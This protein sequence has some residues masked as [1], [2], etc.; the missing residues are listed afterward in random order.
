MTQT[1]GSSIDIQPAL[2]VAARPRTRLPVLT[3]HRFIALVATA[4]VA[5]LVV[6]PAWSA[7]VQSWLTA[8]VILTVVSTALE[9]VSVNLPFDGDLSVATIS[10]VATILLVP[11][12]FAALSVGLSILAEEVIRRRPVS[13]LVFNVSTY[14]VTVSAVSA[15]V[16]LIGAPPEAVAAHDNARV[17]AS[18]LLSALG[19]YAL[20]TA[21]VS[22][23]IALSSGRSVAF[24]LRA[25]TANTAIAET[26]AAMLGGLVALIWTIEPLWT[27]TLSLPAILVSRALHNIRR[28]ENETRDALRSMAQVIDHR[29]PTT[30]HHSERVAAYARALAEELELPDEEVEVIAQAA[31]V[32]D[33]GKIGIPDRILLKEGPLDESEKTVMWLHTEIGAAIVGQF[34]LFR[35]GVRIVLHHHERWDG[36]GYPNGLRGEEIPIGA[37]VVAVADAFDAMTEH[38]PYRA[39]LPVAEALARLQEGAG[40]QWDPAIVPAF[41]RLVRDGRLPQGHDTHAA[42]RGHAASHAADRP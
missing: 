14:I 9:F 41:L 8:F 18:L 2:R 30:Y 31:S 19:Y 26:S 37:R 27:T 13:K 25:N 6:P 16:G 24:M 22:V 38:R 34:S 1:T 33:L 29:D 36:A 23:V 3:P 12:P 35:P 40:S 10:H 39:A 42:S 28:L 4:A 11:P 17:A 5:G 7:S 21:I 20:S 15:G 32:H